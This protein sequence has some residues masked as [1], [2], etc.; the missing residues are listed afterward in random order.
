MPPAFAVV[1][2]RWFWA[3]QL[4]SGI[5][6]WAQTVAQAWLVL[7]LTGSAIALGV[8]TTLQFLP[9]LVFPLLSGVIADRLPRRRVV[10]VAQAGA[11][12]QAVLLALLVSSGHVE[13]WQIGVLALTLGL[14]NAFGNPAQAALVPEIVGRRLVGNAVALNSIQFN[15]ARLLGGA[16]GG[17]LV[18]SVGVAATLLLNAVSFLPSLAV[19][20]V[21]RPA[22]ARAPHER[23]GADPNAAPTRIRQDIGAG[24]RYA[25]GHRP[26]RRVLALFGVV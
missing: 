10:M 13:L 22:H 9:M 17:A 7:Q 20:F 3:S 16:V 11:M 1:E 4:I 23:E 24:L 21:L 25:M 8:I 15:V 2:Y 5:G 12:L 18:A 19:L 26:I 14:S 6:T